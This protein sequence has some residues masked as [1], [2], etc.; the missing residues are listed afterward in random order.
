VHQMAGGMLGIGEGIAGLPR[1][2][3]PLDPAITMLHPG[4]FAPALAPAMAPDDYQGGPA[5]LARYEK[6]AIVGWTP[7][8]QLK[9]LLDF[10]RDR[11]REKEQERARERERERE[12]YEQQQRDFEAQLARLNEWDKRMRE[13]EAER[14]E[15]AERAFAE[16]LVG[17]RRDFGQQQRQVVR[18]LEEQLSKLGS[19]LLT[20]SSQNALMAP[21]SAQA[22]PHL[23]AQPRSYSH[24]DPYKAYGGAPSYAPPSYAPPSYAPPA[25]APPAIPSRV[26]TPAD[27]PYLPPPS[28]PPHRYEGGKNPNVYASNNGD[29]LDKLLMAFLQQGADLRGS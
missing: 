3:R 25:Y 20:S 14:R 18:Q 9:R 11:A 2:T 16:Q 26:G 12:R 7:E 1:I 19:A 27:D 8:D 15:K 22:P 17:M 5:P 13:E 29:E 24:Q 6:P 10:E 28:A 4:G 23:P 21:P